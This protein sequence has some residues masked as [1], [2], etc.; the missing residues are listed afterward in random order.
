MSVMILADLLLNASKTGDYSSQAFQLLEEMSLAYIQM[1]DQLTAN[2]IKSWH[3]YEL[4][5][6]YSIQWLLGA[7]LEYLQLSIAHMRAKT[8]T[9]YIELIQGNR[10]AGGGFQGFFEL[11]E[12]IDTLFEEVNPDDEDDIVRL[13]REAN[14]LFRQFPW[15]PK[16][17]RDILDGKNHLPNNKFRLT[18]FN[19]EDG[20]MGSGAYRQHFFGEMSWMELIYKGAMEQ[21]RYA[22]P[23]L[24]WQRRT[25]KRLA[26]KKSGE[27]T[28]VRS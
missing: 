16:P 2:S 23:V 1:H 22:V 18:L 26:W 6:V 15:L 24:N 8:R 27:A 28:G 3:H 21:V 12:K 11:Q 19:K 13:V 4:W 25:K 20:F 10:L 9:D 5:R 7:Y 14:A 17:F